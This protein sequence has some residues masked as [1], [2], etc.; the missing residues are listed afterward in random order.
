MVLF[1]FGITGR[2][3][4]GKDTTAEYLSKRYGF[5]VLTFTDNVLA[6]MLKSMGKEVTRENLINLAM[7]MRKTFG[8]N[9]ALVPTLC[10]II[11]REGLWAVSGV[12]FPEEVE[13]FRE[14]YGD[15]FKLISVK[16]S[17]KKRFERLKKRGT[18]GE[19]RMTYREFLE[20]EKR[21]TEKPI[22]RVM[23]M[24]D[25]SLDNNGTK[26]E[27]HRQID[28]IYEKLKLGKPSS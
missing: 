17:A 16:C 14:T 13:Y 1:V 6:P 28:D 23:K 18:K 11:R 26:R 10:E 15:A 27:L 4:A 24:A 7:D 21:P 2:R 3:G 22:G 8:G 5:R 25:F 20:V 19:G 12:R 9:A